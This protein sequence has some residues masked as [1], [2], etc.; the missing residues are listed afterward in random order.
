M[1]YYYVASFLKCAYTWIEKSVKG[2]MERTI[3]LGGTFM[4]LEDMAWVWLPVAGT[5]TVWVIWCIVDLKRQVRTLRQ[6]LAE[7]D[8]EPNTHHLAG[9]RQPGSRLLHRPSLKGVR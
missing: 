2:P 5:F 4:W 3:R 9:R 8:A 1:S 6:R 7:F